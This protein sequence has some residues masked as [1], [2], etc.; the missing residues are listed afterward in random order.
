MRARRTC[1]GYSSAVALRVDEANDTRHGGRAPVIDDGQSYS[2]RYGDD[3]RCH[4]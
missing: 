4:H 3:S 2:K 1:G